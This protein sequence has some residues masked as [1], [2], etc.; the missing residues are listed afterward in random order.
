MS[1]PQNPKIRHA[2]ITIFPKDGVKTFNPEDIEYIYNGSIMSDPRLSYYIVQGEYTKDERQHLQIYAQFSTKGERY[3]SIKKIFNDKTLHIEP[4]TYGTPQD[5]RRYC[6][7][8][9]RDKDGNIKTT[10]RDFVEYGT[11]RDNQGKR[12]DIDS[13]IQ[14]IKDGSKLEDMIMDDPVTA[15]IYCQYSRTLEKIEHLTQQRAIRDK[16]KNKFNGVQWRQW[17]KD[18]LDIMH[19]DPHDRHVYWVYDKIGN[20]GKSYISRYLL[21]QDDRPFYITGGTKNDILYAYKGESKIILD[22]PRDFSDR[23]YIYEVIEL[24]KNGQF[25]S[26]KYDSKVMLYDIPQIIVFANFPPQHDGTKLSNDRLQIYQ[27]T[28]DQDLLYMNDYISTSAPLFNRRDINQLKKTTFD[29]V[30]TSA[31]LFDSDYDTDTTFS[32]AEDTDDETVI[33]RNLRKRRPRHAA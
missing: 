19:Q 7:P 1:S 9:Y 2:H 30:S 12:S 10:F 23:T 26:T 22:L 3:T 31:P 11:I 27:L 15:R 16:I 8:D 6:T 29:Y 13:V 32:H 18:V 20:R 28:D 25:L 17:Q 14:K 5:C 21:A 24:L 33:I 4:I